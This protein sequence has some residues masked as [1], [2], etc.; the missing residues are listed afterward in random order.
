MLQFPVQVESTNPALAELY[1]SSLVVPT[2]VAA[3]MGI[4]RYYMP[5]RT[6]HTDDIGTESSHWE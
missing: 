6:K 4:Q 5:P 1:L 2:E 3:S